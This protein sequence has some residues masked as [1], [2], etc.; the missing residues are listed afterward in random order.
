MIYLK[1][2]EKGEIVRIVTDKQ[3]SF[4][5]MD[6]KGMTADSIDWLHLERQA[7]EDES[8]PLSVNFV[9][10]AER[11]GTLYLSESE[12]FEDF[13]KVRG[14]KT[15]SVINLKAAT[16][17]FWKVKCGKEES[18]VSFFDTEDILPRWIFIEGLTNV[19]DVGGW[20]C[21]EKRM[22][23][24]LFY[25]GSELNSH[26]KITRNGLKTMK[27][28]LKIKSVLDLRGSTEL[29]R[30]IYK[31]EYINIPVKAYS[32]FFDEP[33][34]VKAVFSYLAKA[35]NYPIYMHCWGGAD[36]T[37]TIA[38]LL[39]ALLGADI[40]DFLDDYEITTLSIWG[41]RSRNTELFLG[42]IKRLDEFLGENIQ[43][44]TENFLLSCGVTKDEIEKIREIYL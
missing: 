27:D 25:R 22:K 18:E 9:W 29:V 43:E 4:L 39:Q 32:E 3:K 7:K 44:K 15:C 13:I 19:R 1:Y 14:D 8:F 35:E 23:Q 11:I 16:R 38:M 2:P 6:R 30:D 42:T 12:D 37:G 21:G 34:K 24:G 17:Y 40:K 31:K 41:V 28:G 20:Q 26:V 36:R 33:E 10:E 5:E